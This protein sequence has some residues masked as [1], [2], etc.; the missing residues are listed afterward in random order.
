MNN[1]VQRNLSSHIYFFSH[2]L[3]LHLLYIYSLYL[4]IFFSF[5][6]QSRSFSTFRRVSKQVYTIPTYDAAF[7]WI[8]SDDLIRPSFFNAFVP[9]LE[10]ESSERLD[11]HMNPVE[12]LQLLRTFLHNKKTQDMAIKLSC[13]GS[14]VVAQKGLGGELVSDDQSTIFLNAVMGRFEEICNAF[15]RERFDGVMDFACRLD[16]GEYALIEM[17]VIPQNYWDRRALAYVAAFYGN[18]LSRGD[19]WKHI[20]KVIG[21]NILG[22][23]KEDTEHWSDALPG[24]Y[25]RHYKFEDQLNGKKG[26]FIDGIE[27]IQ[28]SIMKAPTVDD[29]EK[30]DWII[31]FKR[32]AYMTE[33]EVEKEIST[34]AVK[35]AFERAK[36]EKLPS[37]V[38]AAYEA[39]HEEYEK[40]SQHTTDLVAKGKLEGRIEEKLQIAKNLISIGLDDDKIIKST[41][42]SSN[43]IK[44]LRKKS[45]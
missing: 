24:E 33:E 5:F 3:Y 4:Y 29:K 8:L 16:N 36:I 25:M 26:R 27:L 37:E 1:V 39:E 9:E 14:F 38:R 44:E 11:E 2:S 35:R 45:K 21:I 40:Y 18:Q 23:G 42:L 34:P 43:E 13:P 10:I 31:F 32:A 15:P 28:Y 17:Q 7:K 20:R 30:Q 12:K 6:K 41:G 19:H 22:G